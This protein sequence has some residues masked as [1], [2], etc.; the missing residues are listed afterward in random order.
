MGRPFGKLRF[1][2]RLGAYVM[3]LL[4]THSDGAM[5]LADT[6]HMSIALV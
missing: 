1:V 4:D 3:Y 2:R 5:D 6:Q